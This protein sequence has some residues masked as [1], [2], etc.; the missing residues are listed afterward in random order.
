M[1]DQAQWRIDNRL[2]KQIE[3]PNFLT[4]IH[5]DMLAKVNPESITI[6]R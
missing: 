1:E 6:I 5:T 2:A 3:V 4:Y